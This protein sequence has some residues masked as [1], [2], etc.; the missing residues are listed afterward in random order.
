MSLGQ[1]LQQ[2]PTRGSIGNPFISWS[3][4]K[5]KI[6]SD[7]IKTIYKVDDNEGSEAL[8]NEKIDILIRKVVFSK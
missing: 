3:D 1:M 2:N 8:N 7:Y 6:A 5:K 4:Q